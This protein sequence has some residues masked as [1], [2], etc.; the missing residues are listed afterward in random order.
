MNYNEA[1]HLTESNLFNI[2]RVAFAEGMLQGHKNEKAE[3]INK[4]AEEF[5]NEYAE[6][7]IKRIKKLLTVSSV[8]L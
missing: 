7:D 8:E 6:K 3:V 5:A 2:I 1:M 4:P